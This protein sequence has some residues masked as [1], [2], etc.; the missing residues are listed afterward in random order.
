MADF[1]L[2]SNVFIE[3]K[4][5]PYGFDIAPRF[6]ELLDELIVHGRIACPVRVYDELLEGADDLAAWAKA[7]RNSGLFV[8][9]DEAVQDAYRRVIEYVMRRYNDNQSRRRFLDRADPWI[10]A[11]A[12]AE[13]GA[14]TTIETR[15]PKNSQKVRIPNVCNEGEFSVHCF[16]TYDMLRKLGVSW[17]S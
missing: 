9:P 15:A 8:E 16:T 3:G 5:G 11:H 17:R 10:I 4:K 13:G 7:Q 1:W 12:M 6:W 14:I 2:D